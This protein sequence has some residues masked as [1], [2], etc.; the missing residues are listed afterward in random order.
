MFGKNK[1]YL[2]KKEF[3]W[4]SF[5]SL[6]LLIASLV[7]N[8]YA[9]YYA[10]IRKSSPVTDIIL[11][12]IRVFDLDAVFVYGTVIF[13]IFLGFL[14]AVDFKWIPFLIKS[15]ALFILIR[16]IFVALTHIGPFPDQVEITSR[17]FNKFTFEADLFFSAHAGLPFLMALMF[18]KN[19]WLRGLFLLWSL[20]FS[21]VVLLAH[22]HYTIDVLSAFFITYAIYKIA[23]FLFKK[24]YK[25]FLSD[26]ENLNLALDEHK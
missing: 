26:V 1:S 4:A 24:D 10:S 11:S 17:I 3:L 9:G 13:F 16:S 21:V 18:W 22:M 15:L 12:N 14:C 19:G 8:F 23:I 5:W 20:F 2:K 7:V 25:I 6:M